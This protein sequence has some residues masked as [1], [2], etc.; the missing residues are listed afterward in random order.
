LLA[1]RFVD[2]QS[3]KVGGIHKATISEVT[4]RAPG[5]R[6]PGPNIGIDDLAH[7]SKRTRRS[8]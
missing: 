5:D 4:E 2:A 6:L 3:L 8:T 1:A 7:H